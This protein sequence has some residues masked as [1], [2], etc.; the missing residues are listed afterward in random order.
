MKKETLLG[1][2]KDSGTFIALPGGNTQAKTPTGAFSFFVIK[3][4]LL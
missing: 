3:L 1:K 4:T 2:L